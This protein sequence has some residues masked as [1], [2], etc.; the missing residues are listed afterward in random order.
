MH[1]PKEI[2]KSKQS[3]EMITIIKFIEFN[4]FFI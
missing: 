1:A 3:I 2:V 4:Y